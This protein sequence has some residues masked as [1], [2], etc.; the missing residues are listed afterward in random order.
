MALPPL[1]TI[2]SKIKSESVTTKHHQTILCLLQLHRF[3]KSRFYR[4]DPALF[5]RKSSGVRAGMTAIIFICYFFAIKLEYEVSPFI[6]KWAFYQ[7][8][9]KRLTD[10]FFYLLDEAAH[11]KKTHK[12]TDNFL[13]R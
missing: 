4:Q 12:D 3:L 8:G 13:S 2:S 11:L 6:L 9:I 10:E 7:K 1:E 5:S